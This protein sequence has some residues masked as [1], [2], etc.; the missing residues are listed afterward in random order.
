MYL[1]ILSSRHYHTSSGLHLSPADE[2]A[3]LELDDIVVASRHE[4]VLEERR[5]SLRPSAGLL[6]QNLE[7]ATRP[8]SSSSIADVGVSRPDFH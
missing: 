4:D 1:D 7:D 3:L 6:S 2:A 5:R 8:S